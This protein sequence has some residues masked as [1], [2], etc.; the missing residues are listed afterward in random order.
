MASLLAYCFAYYLIAG[1]CI[2]IVYHRILV[3]HSAEMVKPLK[4]FFVVLGLPAGTPIQWVGNHRHHHNF[5]DVKGDP[6]SPIVDGFW[7]SHCGWY[8]GTK[9]KLICFLYA[10]AGPIR[11]IIDSYNRPRTNQQFN[12]LAKDISKEKFFAKISQ[13]NTYLILVLSVLVLN[14][15]IVFLYWQ[16]KGLIVMW[17]TSVIVYNL[18]DSV[19]SF[20]H[21]YGKKISEGKNSSRNNLIL[22][23][24]AFGDGWHSNHHLYPWSAKHGLQRG[25]IDVAWTILKIFSFFKVVKNLKTI[26]TYEK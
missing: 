20:G 4:Y 13:P 3:H 11:T 17:I 18:G 22:G 26:N 15:G 21:L 23:F 2:S 10:I 25:Q 19:D 16:L 9:S 5:T 1:I 24:L 7:Y 12:Y 6:H 14:F 8:I